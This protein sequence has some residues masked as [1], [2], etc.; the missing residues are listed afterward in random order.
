M[1]FQW[2]GMTLRHALV[3]A[4][5][6]CLC[7]SWDSGRGGRRFESS[8]SDHY[9]F[10]ER[11]CESSRYRFWGWGASGKG[12]WQRA[13]RSARSRFMRFC[14]KASSPHL[15]RPPRSPFRAAL[16]APRTDLGPALLAAIPFIIITAFVAFW[17]AP[18]LLAPMS[19]RLRRFR[20]SPR[21]RL[22]QFTSRPRQGSPDARQ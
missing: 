17:V 20:F 2:Y 9:Y 6:R 22:R 1:Q 4:V 5:S 21:A 14:C 8:H 19:R 10:A 3:S 12:R 7:G 11:D 18:P 15:C 16:A 13:S